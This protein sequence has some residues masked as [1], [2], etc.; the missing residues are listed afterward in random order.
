MPL[1][2]F[3]VIA[4]WLAMTFDG[5]AEPAMGARLVRAAFFSN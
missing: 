2:I 1:T 3:A 5:R 4:L